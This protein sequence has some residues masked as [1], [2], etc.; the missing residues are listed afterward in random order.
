MKL[1][2][3]AL[4]LFFALKGHTQ[5]K[6]KTT[7][8]VLKSTIT[9]VGS[10]TGYSKD[11]KYIIQQSIGQSGII[12]KKE[13]NAITTQ[14][15]FLTHNI[16][17]KIDNTDI[18]TISESLEFV[19]SPNPFI[20]HIKINFSKITTYDLNIKIY[21]L[22]GKLLFSRKYQPSNVIIVPLDKWSVATYLIQIRS[23]NLIKTKK[24]LKKA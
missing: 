24:I 17:F 9:T 19:I 10:S 15:G 22:N 5:Q 12:G 7:P 11:K 18:D 1:F 2:F 20:D 3:S 13:T 6:A 21:D 23:G 4:I 8:I 16:V 14:Q